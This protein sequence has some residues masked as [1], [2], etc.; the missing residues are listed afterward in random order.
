MAT[1]RQAAAFASSSRKPS[2]SACSRASQGWVDEE[3]RPQSGRKVR[4]PWRAWR[5]GAACP[6]ALL[7][8]SALG[9]RRSIVRG[10]AIGLKS[11]ILD[12][13]LPLFWCV[14]LCLPSARTAHARPAEQHIKYV[15]DGRAFTTRTGL[16]FCALA[17]ACLLASQ[18]K[19]KVDWGDVEAKAK[20][21]A[22][23]LLKWRKQQVR[24]A[25]FFFKMNPQTGAPRAKSADF[26]I[27]ERQPEI[28]R[29]SVLRRCDPLHPHH[30]LP[31]IPCAQTGRGSG[32]R[33]C[34]LGKTRLSWA[35]REGHCAHHLAIFHDFS[36]SPTERRTNLEIRSTSELVSVNVKTVPIYRDS[37]KRFLYFR[38]Y[39]VQGTQQQ[40][41]HPYVRNTANIA[42]LC[43]CIYRRQTHA[44]ETTVVVFF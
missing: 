35:G 4:D 29:M 41:R 37:Y 25:S 8:L 34:P 9:C 14:F 31:C 23:W 6:V 15:G 42:E 17:L 30:T 18:A 33:A 1:P 21:E 24:R 3:G 20:S 27:W 39:Q 19:T 32:W 43:S 40:R 28:I 2:A 26:G 10:G 16:I 13:R 5:S 22:M 38:T 7:R 44:T 12:A 36:F 11:T